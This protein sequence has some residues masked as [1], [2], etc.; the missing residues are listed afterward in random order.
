MALPYQIL[1]WYGGHTCHTACGAPVLCP[2]F[3]IYVLI[4]KNLIS[5]SAT[6]ASCVHSVQVNYVTAAALTR[7]R[8][9]GWAKKV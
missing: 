7:C 3:V 4:N 6:D 9:T 5:V 1:N 8:P 2:G